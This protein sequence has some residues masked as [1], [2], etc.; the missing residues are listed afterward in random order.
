MSVF[1]PTRKLYETTDNEATREWVS[2]PRLRSSLHISVWLRGPFQI[3]LYSSL[4]T[5]FNCKFYILYIYIY[6]LYI[7]IYILPWK[8]YIY[9]YIYMCIP[10]PS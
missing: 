8:L 7:Y 5:L 9:I 10:L 1:I 3:F 4:K 2:K 6:I